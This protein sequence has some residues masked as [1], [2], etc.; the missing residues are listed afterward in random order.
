MLLVLSVGAYFK[1][2]G[3]ITELDLAKLLGKRPA[4][5]ADQTAG[6]APMNILVMGSDTRALGT[7][8]FGTTKDAAGARSD[9]TLIV[10]LSA[11]RKSAV[12][13]SIP[14]DS[15]TKAPRDC[16]D[17]NSKVADGPIRQWNANFS[18]GGPA[19]LIRTVEGNTGIYI[20]H[21]V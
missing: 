7:N 4:H 16:K 8:A 13:V 21:F 3:N 17:S 19:C 12:V 1:L 18:L 6:L 14:R 15:M 11:D 2:N 5:A 9:T 20:D 10:H